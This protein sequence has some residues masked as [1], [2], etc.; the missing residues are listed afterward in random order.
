MN[1]TNSPPAIA[2]LTI[3]EVINEEVDAEV[4]SAAVL[5]LVVSR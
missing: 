5:L 4:A 1:P 2:E 3:K